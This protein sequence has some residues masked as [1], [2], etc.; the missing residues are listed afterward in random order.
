MSP[1]QPE[2]AETVLQEAERLT[3]DDRQASYGPPHED[4]ARFAQIASAATG[5]DI[6]PEHYPALMIAAKLARN[7]HSFKRDNLV[8][9]AGYCRVAERIHDAEL[10]RDPIPPESERGATRGR[11]RRPPAVAPRAPSERL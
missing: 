4:A 5:L 10:S 2:R 1:P 3:S 11:P 6:R 9:I 7:A 8:D